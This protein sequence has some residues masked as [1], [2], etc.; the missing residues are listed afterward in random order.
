MAY[1]LGIVATDVGGN[2]EAVRHQLDGI[3]VPAKIRLKCPSPFAGFLIEGRGGRL[4][5]KRA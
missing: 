5:E 2:T 1:G 3:I 4:G